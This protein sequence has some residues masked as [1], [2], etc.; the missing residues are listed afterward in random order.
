MRKIILLIL[1]LTL[2][3][4][5]PSRLFA[6]EDWSGVINNLQHKDPAIRKSAADLL[7]VN[8][9]KLAVY[10]LIEAL[11]DENEP[12]RIA[13]ATAL[14]KITRLGRGFDQNY[15]IWKQW[16]DAKGRELYPTEVIKEEKIKPLE[17]KLTK[18]EEKFSSID[19]EVGKVDKEVDKAKNEIKD[20][21]NEI[22]L[23][24]IVAVV[25]FIVFLIVIIYFTG[26]GASRLKM[27][28]ET[29]K[30]ADFYVQKSEEVT[31]RTD[32]VLEEL[33]AK[34][35]EILGFA[36]KVKEDSQAEVER[37]VEM[38]ETNLE[39]KMREVVMGLREKA[40]RE[41]EQ[42]LGQIKTQV[43]YDI[44]KL[45]TEYKEKSDS[46]FKQKETAFM[47]EFEVHTLF[48]E[49]AFY[50]INGKY[51]TALKQYNKLLALKSEHF[52]AW[53][54]KGNILKTL[55]RYNEAIEA[56]N[57]ALELSPD[58]PDI[59]YNIATTYALLKRKDKMLQHLAKA[60]QNDGE[61]K[62]EAINDPAFREYWNDPTF[63]NLTE[64]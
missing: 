29:I 15:T 50:S 39:H 53:T 24:V 45:M 57:H 40:E 19:K 62:D 12:V 54:N 55:M 6:Q 23:L 34:K 10:P 38:M 2:I 44:R 64:A 37:F 20:A 36:N 14:E 60:L 48:I 18:L 28:K 11:R 63:R 5:T 61:Y 13:A 4:F 52:V 7:G 27:W 26:V 25:I 9:V 8:S 16:W 51:D 1:L 47:R 17:E 49:A 58:S 22:R 56:Y 41:I 31:K 35:M 42:T 32:N 3:L 46:E 33:E 30:Q 43:D 21:K 59:L